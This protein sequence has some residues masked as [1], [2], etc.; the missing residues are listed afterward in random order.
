MLHRAKFPRV[1]FLSDLQPPVDPKLMPGGRVGPDV[2]TMPSSPAMSNPS[3][4]PGQQTIIFPIT[5]KVLDP[6]HYASVIDGN[7]PVPATGTPSTKVV[8]A[9]PVY[10]NFLAIR[11]TDAASNVLVG[12]GRQANANSTL[13]LAP[14]QIVLF[15][16]V[17]PQGDIYVLS[18][19]AAATVSIAYSNI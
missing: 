4:T 2:P 5:Q 19:A 9:A 6:H 11:N 3:T 12:F 10:R 17:V 1:E 18:S 13:S 7:F 14:G 8:D 15:D 16:T